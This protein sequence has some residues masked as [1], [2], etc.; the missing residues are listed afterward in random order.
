MVAAKTTPAPAPAA[1]AWSPTTRGLLVLVAIAMFGALLY[2]LCALSSRHSQGAVRER[3]TTEGFTS[4]R[5]RHGHSHN[6]WREPCPQR[7]TLSKGIRD[8]VSC[9]YLNADYYGGS[10]S[11]ERP[12]FAGKP[13]CG[14]V[15][16][17]A[18]DCDCVYHTNKRVH[19][20]HEVHVLGDRVF[21]AND[22]ARQS[23]KQSFV[24]KN[25]ELE[26]R[27]DELAERKAEQQRR[28]AELATKAK[29]IAQEATDMA[30]EFAGLAQ[31]FQSTPAKLLGTRKAELAQWRS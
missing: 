9:K 21:K 1:A 20:D 5:N 12:T 22:Q 19:F 8:L 26:D 30:P 13:L 11:G 6:Y 29:A 14:A 31:Q 23:L 2:A 24:A 28:S 17:Q 16:V 25:K 7:G 3:R 10:S 27:L 18:P 15:G 4:N